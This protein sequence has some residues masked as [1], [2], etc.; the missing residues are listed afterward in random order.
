MNNNNNLD[1]NLTTVNKQQMNNQMNNRLNN[2]MNNQMGMGNQIDTIN[3]LNNLMNTQPQQVLKLTTRLQ[4]KAV[5][6][7]KLLSLILTIF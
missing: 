3:S 1:M 5:I 4:K 2:R 7:L 6:S